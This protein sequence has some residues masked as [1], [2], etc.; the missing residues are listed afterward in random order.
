MLN[1][2]FPQHSPDLAHPLFES[3]IGLLDFFLFLIEAFDVVIFCHHDLGSVI[4]LASE[5]RD[6]SFQGFHVSNSFFAPLPP[7]PCPH[8]SSLLVFP[9]VL[10]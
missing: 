9:S 10:L 7:Q 1:S 3:I 5:V 4:E 6:L 8:G 2:F